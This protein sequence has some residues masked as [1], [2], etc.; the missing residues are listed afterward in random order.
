MV[1]AG[2]GR[3]YGMGWSGDIFG[4]VLTFSYPTAVQQNLV[5]PNV[6]YYA[7]NLTQGPAAY[8]FPAIPSNGNY[9][10]PNGVQQPTRPLTM[11]VPT[12]DSWNMMIQQQLTN[13][14]ALQIGYVGSHGI[15]NMFDSS[16]QAN[17]NQQTL[18]GFNCVASGAP[19]GCNLALDPQTGL[20]YTLD[21]RY[22][23]YDGTAQA[24]LGVNFG[25]PFGWTQGL[26]YNA[27]Q[28]TTSYQALQVVFQKRYAQGFQILSNYT[29]SHARAHESDY[30]FINPRAD[31]GNSYY[32]RTNAFILSG[33]WDLPFGKGKP[34]GGNLTGWANQL[35]SGWALNGTLTVESGLPF[36][37]SYSLCAEDQDIDGQGGSLCRP[38]GIPGGPRATLG[39]QGF[40]AIGH[41]EAY[42]TPVPTLATAGQVSG[43][44]IRPFPGTFG[45]IERDSLFGPGLINT[46]LALAKS[47][48]MTERLH[49]Q[50]TVQAFNLF[51]HPNLNNPSSCVDCGSSSGL[52]TDIVASQDGTTMRRLQFAGRFQF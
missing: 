26:R 6:N 29:W 51:N 14:A 33:N 35:A 24:D 46:D 16:N 52:I 32:N 15:H 45:N 12:L 36:T 34:L 30:Y 42:F 50:A 7:F 48:N 3:T 27:N 4:E 23:Y 9:P 43:P 18:A 8:N 40:N 2:Y 37:P 31:Y 49:F 5:A 21:E 13:S 11:R 41:S 28:A 25:D 20:P 19:A 44:Y 38:N 22:P 10:L 1:R 17:P 47:F 39:T